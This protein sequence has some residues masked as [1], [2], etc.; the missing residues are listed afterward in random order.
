MKQSF[1]MC[2]LLTACAIVHGNDESENSMGYYNS[3]EQDAFEP[4]SIERIPNTPSPPVRLFDSPDYSALNPNRDLR[5]KVI[6]ANESSSFYTINPESIKNCFKEATIKTLKE[7]KYY[8][9]LK[10]VLR[11]ALSKNLESCQSRLLVCLK[12]FP[13]LDTKEKEQAHE[14][15]LLLTAYLCELQGQNCDLFYTHFNQYGL[16][17][18]DELERENYDY[19]DSDLDPSFLKNYF[20]ELSNIPLEYVEDVVSHS[21]DSS[22]KTKAINLLEFFRN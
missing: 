21:A 17:K 11:D 6:Q 18:L 22:L 20:Q 10:V 8:Q 12:Y 1:L 19:K 5:N 16:D 15:L 7:K 3:E 13:E 4:E 9:E 14:N 2:F